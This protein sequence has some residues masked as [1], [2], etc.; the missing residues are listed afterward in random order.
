MP[1]GGRLIIKSESAEN[2]AIFSFKDTG[3]GMTEEVMSKIWTPLFTTKA[4]GMGFGLAICKRV[5]DAH[6]GS[7]SAE[8]EVGKGSVFTVTFPI[9][10]K[11]V[12]EKQGVHLSTAELVEIAASQQQ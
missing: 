3:T 5:I 7:I 2:N 8:S 10:P 12:E 9:Q 11:T 4:R 6:G 1:N